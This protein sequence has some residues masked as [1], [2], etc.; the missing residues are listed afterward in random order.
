MKKSDLFKIINS[1]FDDLFANYNYHFPRRGDTKNE[2]GI[3]ENGQWTKSTYTSEDGTISYTSFVRVGDGYSVNTKQ[4]KLEELKSQLEILVQ[5]Q[6]FEKAAELRDK[7]K[8]VEKNSESINQ[9][10]SKLKSLVE[11]QE[12]EEAAKV[13]DQIKELEK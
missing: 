7:I 6:E 5:K 11:N 9:L 8:L 2:S 3:D 10:K 13:R 1:T 12:F 4:G